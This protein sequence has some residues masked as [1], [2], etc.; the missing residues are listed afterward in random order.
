MSANADASMVK[1]HGWR[2]APQGV[3]ARRNRFQVTRIHARR[4]TAEVVE[5]LPRRNGADPPLIRNAMGRMVPPV[6]PNLAIA[7][8]VPS[9]DP[10][11][12]WA[13]VKTMIRNW[14][15][16]INLSHESRLRG[17]LATLD[18]TAFRAPAPN[19]DRFCAI[20]TTT[21]RTD[22][23]HRHQANL[24]VSDPGCYQHAGVTSCL[25]FNIMVR[26]LAI[27]CESNKAPRD[28]QR[29]PR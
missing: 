28:T 15:V 25:H 2:L 14:P 10:N 18:R 7:N 17:T 26:D 19:I 16:L 6:D 9:A 1:Q 11:P 21:S 12:A 20:G 23:L 5:L 4:E 27:V 22:T 24:L 8:L 3:F 29:V 13:K